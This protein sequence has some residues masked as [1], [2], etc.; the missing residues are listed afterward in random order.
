VRLRERTRALQELRKG[1]A[2]VLPSVGEHGASSRPE[3]SSSFQP[4]PTFS[5]QLAGLRL[6]QLRLQTA[7]CG[8][9]SHQARS[10][11]LGKVS[12]L[13]QFVPVV[14]VSFCAGLGCLLCTALL[15]IAP[16]AC[17][18][19]SLVYF[20]SL[21]LYFTPLPDSISPALPS[22][23]PLLQGKRLSELCI[24]SDFSPPC[25]KTPPCLALS[26]FSSA[27]SLG[28]PAGPPNALSRRRPMKRPI[29]LGGF[30]LLPTIVFPSGREVI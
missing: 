13:F 28:F 17:D 15:F 1:H 5:R 23:P 3:P 11:R 19:S 12:P 21:H 26:C 16:F 9:W 8:F 22:P 25:I 14:F 27:V 30:G 24:G 29:F 7:R 20:T 10:G 2:R 4:S 6:R 18:A